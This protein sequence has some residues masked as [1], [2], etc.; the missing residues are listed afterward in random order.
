MAEVG[1]KVYESGQIIKTQSMTA[2]TGVPA[3][4][5]MYGFTTLMSL[6]VSLVT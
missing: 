5:H 2:T 1:D 3:S 6:G 4:G